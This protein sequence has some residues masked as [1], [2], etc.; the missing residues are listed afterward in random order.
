MHK[1]SDFSH[2]L[3]IIAGRTDF[4][5]PFWLPFDIFIYSAKL[6][7]LTCLKFC[8][9]FFPFNSFS[10]PWLNTFFDQEG[11]RGYKEAI[12]RACVTKMPGLRMDG[13]NPF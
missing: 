11:M 2:H 6:V 10:V 5:L 12:N 13:E 9:F 1:A 8:F 7:S 4:N 3:A